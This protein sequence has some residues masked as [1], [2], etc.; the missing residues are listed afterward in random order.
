MSLCVVVDTAASG[1]LRATDTVPCLSFVALTVDE[2]ASLNNSPLN[3]SAG[4]GFALS[5]AVIGVWAA[6]F[7]VRAAVRALDTADT[8]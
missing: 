2:Y 3:L 4:D 1:V 5:V 8:D 7:A 6:G